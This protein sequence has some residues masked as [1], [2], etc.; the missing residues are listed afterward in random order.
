VRKSKMKAGFQLRRGRTT[1]TEYLRKTAGA[2]ALL[3]IRISCAESTKRHR[4][5]TKKDLSF[6]ASVLCCVLAGTI[7]LFERDDLHLRRDT[8][9]QQRFNIFTAFAALDLALSDQSI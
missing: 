3:A 8:R 4:R 7:P 1:G 6:Q 9:P 5:K 2:T